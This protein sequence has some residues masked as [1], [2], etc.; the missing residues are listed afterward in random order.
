VVVNLQ[1]KNHFVMVNHVNVLQLIKINDH[2]IYYFIFKD[3]Y[4]N[5]F[6]QNERIELN[7]KY[8]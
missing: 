3:K 6:K 2:L 5:I 8:N 4:S 1:Q 7:I